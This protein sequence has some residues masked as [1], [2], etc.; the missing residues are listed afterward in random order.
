MKLS[1]LVFDDLFNAL[2]QNVLFEIVVVGHFLLYPIG[3]DAVEDDIKG[4]LFQR[5]QPVF[6]SHGRLVL[7]FGSRF[8]I[9]FVALHFE[10]FIENV[11]HFV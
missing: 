2:F 10:Q 8:R 5:L 11:L 4:S 1:H 3:L 6:V 9:Q 7:L